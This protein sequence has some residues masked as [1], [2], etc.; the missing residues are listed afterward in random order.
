M[1]RHRHAFRAVERSVAK[2]ILYA[3]AKDHSFHLYQR[4]RPHR[5][6]EH[7]FEGVIN[8]LQ[9]RYRETD[10]MAVKKTGQF[11]N[12]KECPSCEGARLRVE[13]RY[14][15]VGNASRSAR[16][17]RSADALARDAG[18]FETLKLTG[19]RKKSPTH[20]QGNQLAADLPE[21]CRLD[22]LSLERSADTLSGG[23][24]SAIRLAR[25]SAPPDRRHVCAG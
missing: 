20:H 16:S 18:L 19:A 10:S 9:R 2:V 1:I 14:V 11:I 3:P 25:K 8:N 5:D 23:K 24:R 17:M 12:E 13:A 6:Q 22:Y 4:A 7:T 21:Q 15:K